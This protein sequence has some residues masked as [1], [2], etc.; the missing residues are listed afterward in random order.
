M[1]TSASFE[2]RSAPSSYPT[3]GRRGKMTW[4]DFVRAHRV[5]ILA[6]DFFT[7]ETIWLQRLY[8]L[9]FIELGSR[10]V[11]VAGC[12][13]NPTAVLRKKTSDVFQSRFMRPSARDD[14]LGADRRALP[15]K[16]RRQHKPC[17]SPKQCRSSPVR[18]FGSSSDARVCVR[19]IRVERDASPR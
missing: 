7:V 17:R 16:N 10:R 8:V 18:Q 15:R 1:E 19:S 5:S 12:T 9:F 14:I 2:A 11:H 13:P 6:V 3:Q 4:R